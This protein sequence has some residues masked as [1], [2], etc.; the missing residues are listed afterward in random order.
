MMPF[1]PASVLL[2]FIGLALAGALALGLCLL[3][4]AVC[5]RLGW[6]DQPTP[7]R[8]HRRPT[9]RLGG[10]AIFLAFLIT[11]WLLYRP[12]TPFEGRVIGGMLVALAIIVAVMAYDD[13]RGLPPSL[14]LATQ[15]AAALIIMFPAGRGMI[16]EVIHNPL[17]SADHGRIWLPLWLAVP[18]TWFWLTGMMNTINW[19]DGLDGLAG[20]VVTIAALVMAAISWTLGQPGAALLCA[21]LAGAT[22]G[23]LPLNGLFGL[24]PARLFMGDCGAMFL[25]LALATLANVGGARLATTLILLGLPICDAVRVVVWRLQRRSPIWQ[26]DRAH[27]HHLLLA[28]G[29][30][31]RRIVWLFYSIT[32]LFGGVIILTTYLGEQLG[33]PGAGIDWSF[34]WSLAPWLPSQLSRFIF[35]AS[36]LTALLELA[37]VTLTVVYLW[38]LTRRPGD[39]HEGMST[40]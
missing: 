23:F 37:L 7:R 33:A 39:E 18:F 16:I 38:R 40:Q 26:F 24:R 3:V 22:L 2:P 21:I 34:Q 36:A 35:T 1:H 29:L 14:K 27:L 19:V 32:A 15:T 17:L 10:I 5:R 20:G 12:A 30:S 31:P 25:G 28:G 6:L 4:A 13:I 9:P 8:T 11:S